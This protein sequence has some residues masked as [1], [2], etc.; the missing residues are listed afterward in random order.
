LA[1][2]VPTPARGNGYLQRR[3]SLLKAAPEVEVLDRPP[4]V[5]AAIKEERIVPRTFGCTKP[6]PGG[7]L[8]ITAN[9]V[10]EYGRARFLPRC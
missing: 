1:L 2:R 4:G 9:E 7:K 5:T 8:I 10:E 6:V 3:R